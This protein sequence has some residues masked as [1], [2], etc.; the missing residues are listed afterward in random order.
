MY[1]L[2]HPPPHWKIRQTDLPPRE[3]SN[4]F[5][6]GGGG[7]GV[8]RYFLELLILFTV[9]QPLKN[10][11]LKLL[12]FISGH[13]GQRNHSTSIK[14]LLLGEENWEHPPQGQI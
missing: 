3:K 5:R 14:S 13:I 6:R 11:K 9:I 12:T 10:P 1:P 2:G 7:G 4:L 8:G